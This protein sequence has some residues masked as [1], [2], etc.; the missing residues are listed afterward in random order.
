[1]FLNI[2]EHPELSEGG[3]GAWEKT[4]MEKKISFIFN[5][6]SDQSQATQRGK[7]SWW[8]LGF[9]LLTWVSLVGKADSCQKHKTMMDVF[10]FWGAQSF[11][12][13]P[14]V[15][16]TSPCSAKQGCWVKP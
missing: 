9:P 8:Y 1:M 13:I 10:P 4:Q 5:S 12:W 16:E 7:G 6:L 14:Q 15:L 3:K 2:R 11:V